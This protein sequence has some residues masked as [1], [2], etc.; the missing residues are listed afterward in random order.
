MY[1][2]EAA[3]S[4]KVE[5]AIPQATEATGLDQ[6]E[7]ELEG[8]KPAAPEAGGG[9]GDGEGEK[10]AVAV[11]VE[12]EVKPAEAVVKN[13]KEKAIS[14]EVKGVATATSTEA[15]TAPGE[16]AAAEAAVGDVVE[17]GNAAAEAEIA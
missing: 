13:E 8:K 7:A 12:A 15:E 17:E 2:E 9:S 11:A 16:P 14:G 3:G 4:R 5:A 10:E 1:M 6:V